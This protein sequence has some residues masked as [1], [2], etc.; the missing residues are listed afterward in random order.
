MRPN[1]MLYVRA[2]GS[3]FVVGRS[4]GRMYVIAGHVGHWSTRREAVAAGHAMAGA[5]E[6][7]AFHD[8]S[9]DWQLAD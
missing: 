2:D 7:D 4:V 1:F 6:V 9:V 3:S 5:D 8:A